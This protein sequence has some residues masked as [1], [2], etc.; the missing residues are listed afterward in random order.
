MNIFNKHLMF[1]TEKKHLQSNKIYF[2]QFT[3]ISKIFQ[4]QNCF[5][6]LKSIRLS[7]DHES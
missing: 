7:D 2:S 1:N 3:I 6:K 5:N 4:Y